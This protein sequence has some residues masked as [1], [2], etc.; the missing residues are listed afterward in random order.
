MEDKELR[1]LK[2][3]QLL[4][5]LYQQQKRIEELENENEYLHRELSSKQILLDKAGNIANAS[6]V[7]SEV[8]T[9]AQKAADMYLESVKHLAQRAREHENDGP[10]DK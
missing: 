8:F 5:I 3:M 10:A 1:R 2:R 7:I 6:L 4:E 9:R